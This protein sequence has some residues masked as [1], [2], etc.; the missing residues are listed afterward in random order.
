MLRWFDSSLLKKETPRRLSPEQI[1]RRIL[2]VTQLMW[3]Q[4]GWE[5]LRQAREESDVDSVLL[6]I[7]S[8][9]TITLTAY[10]HGRI[11][12]ELWSPR[13]SFHCPH[14]RALFALSRISST[15]IQKHSHAL[16]SATTSQS[17][18][19]RNLIRHSALHDWVGACLPR[20]RRSW[21]WKG[22]FW[23]LCLRVYACL[24]RVWRTILYKEL[25]VK[26]KIRRSSVVSICTTH[27]KGRAS[28]YYAMVSVWITIKFLPLQ[29]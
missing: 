14:T 27:Y 20:C 15:R 17:L 8:D 4:N 25:N 18:I 19:K 21:I 23:E 24:I 5:Q 26:H 12:A 6:M 22:L 11:T 3:V 7:R 10:Y 28:H 29:R 9:V 16:Y 13:P 1:L 2:W